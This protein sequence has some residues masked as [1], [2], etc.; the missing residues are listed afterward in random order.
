MDEET[1]TLTRCGRYVFLFFLILERSE[2]IFLDTQILLFL[3]S[4]Y[5]QV[6]ATKTT[7]DNYFTVRNLC[8]EIFIAL[9]P[10][11]LKF[12]S[13]VGYMGTIINRQPFIEQIVG[14]LLFYR[15]KLLMVVLCLWPNCWMQKRTI[16]T[17]QT[18]SILFIWCVCYISTSMGLIKVSLPFLT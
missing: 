6:E 16:S 13:S 3:H 17:A 1:A 9:K 2:L 15:K 8:P 18:L 14:L 11:V 5:Y 7:I 4:C 12:T 10:D